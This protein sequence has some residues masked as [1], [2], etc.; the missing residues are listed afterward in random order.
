MN[1]FGFGADACPGEPG[2]VR[3]EEGVYIMYKHGAGAVL[4]DRVAQVR[5]RHG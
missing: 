4:G 1:N 2:L 3:G 5:E